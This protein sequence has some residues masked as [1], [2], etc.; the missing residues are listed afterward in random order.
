M[1]PSLPAPRS[2]RRQF[3]QQGATLAAGAA[4]LGGLVSAVHG[5]ED[6]TIRLALIG[7]GG[8][9]SGAV[10]NALSVKDEG[11]SSCMRWPT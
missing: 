6:T 2:T 8:R 7:C 9:G 10:D 4:T 3:L 1:T 5:A 11:R